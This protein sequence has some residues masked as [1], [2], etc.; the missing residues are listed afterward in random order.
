ESVDAVSG[1]RVRVMDGLPDVPQLVTPDG[2]DKSLVVM[3]HQDGGGLAYFDAQHSTLSA[4]QL[5]MIGEQLDIT[6][7]QVVFSPERRLAAVAL[8]E[9][10]NWSLQLA[11]PTAPPIIAY[12][13]P[14]DGVSKL[15]WSAD[16][17]QLFYAFQNGPLALVRSDGRPIQT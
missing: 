14:A 9:G 10:V 4:Y 7:S 8:Y 5:D 17:Q 2:Q 11:S 13:G 16:G 1:T 15:T 3:W 6:R 12:R